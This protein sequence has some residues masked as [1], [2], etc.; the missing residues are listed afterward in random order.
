MHTLPPL[1]FLY[2]P[3]SFTLNSLLQHLPISEPEIHGHSHK[4]KPTQYSRPVLVMIPDG[5]PLADLIH[6]P[7]V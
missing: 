2:I 4:Q 1:I 3:Y 5:P 7:Q 6:A